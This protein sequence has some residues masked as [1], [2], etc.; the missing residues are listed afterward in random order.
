LSRVERIVGPLPGF[1]EARAISILALLAGVI[2]CALS[3]YFGF[4]GETFMGRPL[5]GDFVQFYAAGKILNS[6]PA[7]KIY[8][9]S[10]IVRVEQES[11]PSMPESQM[12]LFGNPPY[13][14]ELFRPL[15]L[16]PY[17]EA[18]CIWLV[19]SLALYAVALALLLPPAIRNIGF[20]L[21]FSSPIFL[22]ETWIG[23]QISVFAFLA[24]ALFVSNFRKRRW[25]LAGLSLSIAAYKPSLIAVPAIMFL[26]GACWRILSGLIAGCVTSALAATLTGALRPWIGTLRVFSTLATGHDV[27]IRR[28]KYVDFNSFFS[29]LLGATPAAR[30]FAI[31]A[32]AAAL[33]W[34]ARAWW[35]SRR[36][37]IKP[38]LLAAT[39][40]LMLAANFYVP[41]YDSIILAAAVVLA[42]ESGKPLRSWLPLLYLT[43]FL[44]QSFAEFAH[45][46]LL[47]PVLASFG[48]WLTVAQTSVCDDRN[49]RRPDSSRP[50][51]SLR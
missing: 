41:V 43:P 30:A 35:S 48:L 45:L 15:A 25:F 6:G 39:F 27:S 44:S 17:A 9:L 50:A 3:L 47:T 32:T 42:W 38:Q 34:L 23:G 49:V 7:A 37:P 14:A 18:Y 40:A 13:I 33:V 19:I 24:V 20:L 1:K 16:V 46:Q 31:L 22:L 12:L 10:T 11:C 28:V 8:D 26:I 4:H 51:H 5:G 2:L 21:A 29:I 36:R